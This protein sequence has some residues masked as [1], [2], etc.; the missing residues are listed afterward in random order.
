MSSAIGAGMGLGQQWSQNPNLGSQF[1]TPHNN[2]SGLSGH[3]FGGSGSVGSIVGNADPVGNLI[4]QV[5]GDPLNI[6]G[7]KNNPNA[8]LF[9]SSN[10][11]SSTSGVPSV[12]PTLPNVG[13]PTLYNPSSFGGLANFGSGKYNQ[14][15]AQMAGPQYQPM[16]MPS[17]QQKP[18]QA[19][20]AGG[21]PL[22]GGGNPIGIGINQPVVRARQ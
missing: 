7:N 13:A 14:M 2:L 17:T 11:S 10:G 16:L 9:P 21:A 15:A 8:L 19:S 20:G 1:S 3:L 6:Y 22:A 5:G 4:T 18:G 12:L